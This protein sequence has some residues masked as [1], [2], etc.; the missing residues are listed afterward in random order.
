MKTVRYVYVLNLAENVL[1]PQEIHLGALH[2]FI[3]P[4]FQLEGLETEGEME[5]EQTLFQSRIIYCRQ[6][7]LSERYRRDVAEELVS[8]PVS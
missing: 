4:S 3:G 6:E 2:C 8:F 1:I 7:L 5:E